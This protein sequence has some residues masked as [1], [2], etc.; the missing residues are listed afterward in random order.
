MKKWMCVWLCLMLLFTVTAG[1]GE[2]KTVMIP[3]LET[4]S[5]ELPENDALRFVRA[6]K[7][8]WNLGNTF[9]AYNCTWLRNPMD[10]ESAW[11][12]VKT[13]EGLVDAL[14]AA[15]FRTLRIPVSW[16]NHLD[17]ALRIDPA[18]LARVKEVASWAYGRG[19]FVILNIHHDCDPDYYYPDSAHLDS[20][21]E[22]LRT[23][24]TQLAETFGDW[25]E[26]LIFECINEPRLTKDPAHEWWWVDS[27]PACQDAMAAICR[28]NQVFVDT[29]RA[30]GERN[31][32]RY[33]MV[34]SYD[35][36]PE[37]AC[38]SSFTLPEDSAENRIIVSAHAYSP[39]SFA[40][41]MPGTDVFDLENAAH[42]AGITGFL[43]RLYQRYV[44][45]G[46]PVLMGEFGAMEKN[47]NLQSR[48][49]WTGFYVSEARA[50]GITCCWWDNNLFQGNG[51]RFGLFDRQTGRCI[52]PEILEAFMQYCE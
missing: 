32:D 34:P 33:L 43:D 10:Y 37:Y 1:T 24:W 14:Y 26:R 28:L 35:A 44:S 21:S 45:Q 49:N 30:A 9:D 27:D 2:E 39:Y 48:V 7:A 4:G 41:E 42:R 6:M 36:N 52:Y 29:V 5:Y 19:M 31:A 18:W 22:Y 13:P 23:I 40:L 51:E 15:G 46:I 25:D 8:G 11:C 20:A 38:H 16:H 50:R 47:G 17:G 12:G 3:K